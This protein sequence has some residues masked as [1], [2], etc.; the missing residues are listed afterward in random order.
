MMGFQMVLGLSPTVKRGCQVSVV[1][2]L[3]PP[4]AFHGVPM[5]IEVRPTM[6]LSVDKRKTS[7]IPDENGC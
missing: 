3:L 5:D 2:V 4:L 7:C 6:T 1:K